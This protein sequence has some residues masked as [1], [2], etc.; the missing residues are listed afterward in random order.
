MKIICFGD[1]NTYGFD[2]RDV[3]GGRYAPADRWPDILAAET[4]WIVLNEGVN[5]RQIPRNP[6]PLRLL[7]VHQPVD[8]FLVMLGTNDLLQ[9][10][11]AGETA[12]RMEHFLSAMLPHFPK[13][14]LIAPP[15]LKRGAW[16]PD[17]KLVAESIRLSTEYRLV[18]QK[19][20]IP[21]TDTSSWQIPLAFDGVHFTEEGNRIFAQKLLLHLP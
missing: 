4:G 11:S 17:E 5:G 21:F 12:A 19:L 14:L 8:L 18:A 16:V 1:S 6:Y 2:P 7:Q 9:G 13:I 20:G 10:A 3:F 15:P